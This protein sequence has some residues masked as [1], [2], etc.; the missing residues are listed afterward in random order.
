[1]KRRKIQIQT[2]NGRTALIIA[3]AKDADPEVVR[4]L[5][6]NGADPN[7]QTENGRSALMADV[8][9]EVVVAPREFKAHASRLFVTR[10]L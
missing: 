6:A 1:M 5:I 9:R 10:V 2:E 3:A 8:H 4:L 7:I